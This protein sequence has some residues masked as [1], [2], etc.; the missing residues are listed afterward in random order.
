MSNC[1][2]STETIRTVRD[3]EPRTATSTFTLLLSSV[4]ISSMLLYVH[5]DHIIKTISD[6]EPGTA[7]LTFTQLLSSGVRGLFSELFGLGT[8]L[9]GRQS[10]G[11]PHL[12]SP[13]ITLR[14]VVKK[15][16]LSLCRWS[17]FGV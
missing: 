6:G 11:D 16:F 15:L 8:I 1:F 10:D 9:F 7:T 17:R 4:N 2:T 13:S 14:Q 12:F 3:G 5:R